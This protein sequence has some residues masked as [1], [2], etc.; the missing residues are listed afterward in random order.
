MVERQKV[1]AGRS[2]R[3]VATIQVKSHGDLGEVIYCVGSE[4]LFKH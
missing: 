3:T 1:M 2:F 4:K